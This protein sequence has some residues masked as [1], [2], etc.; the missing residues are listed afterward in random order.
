MLFPTLHTARLTVRQF[1]AADLAALLG[2]TSDA[3]VMRYIPE[4]VFGDE[5]AQTFIA[6]HSSEQ[7]TSAAVTLAGQ[8]EVIGHVSF[9]PWYA[10]RTFELGWVFDP[11]YQGQGY[12]TEAAA[13][14]RDFGF[15]ELD[16]HRIIATCQPENPASYR[17]MEKLGMRREGHFRQC[18]DR[19][20]G[21]WWD[22]YFYAILASEWQTL[23]NES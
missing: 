12:A 16:L 2:Y 15:A 20:N 14:L 6:F 22:E 10:P 8:D 7:A 4:G 13:A 11:R 3:D 9:H 17:V 18:I 21:V 23:K 19:G 5:E 1:A